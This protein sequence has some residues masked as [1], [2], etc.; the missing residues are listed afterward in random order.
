MASVLRQQAEIGALPFAARASMPANLPP[1]WRGREGAREAERQIDPGCDR[2]TRDEIGRFVWT[3]S[4]ASSAWSQSAIGKIHGVSAATTGGS[5]LLV[6][7]GFDAWEILEAQ[8]GVS[9]GRTA[10]FFRMM[11]GPSERRS[12]VRAAP[13]RPI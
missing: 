10:G 9:G 11:G 2:R 5:P 13:R 1:P 3:V 4:T 6:V 7:P 12:G 8:R